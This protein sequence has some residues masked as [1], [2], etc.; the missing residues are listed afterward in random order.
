LTGV[1]AA[2][3]VTVMLLFL[4]GLVQHMP[5][6]VLAAVV[7]A[8]SISLFE[9]SALRHLWRMRK[10]EL[11]LAVVS[12]LGVALVGV[13]EGIVIAVILSILQFFERA[14]RPYSAVLGKMDE[15]PGHHDIQRHPEARQIP[16]LIILRWDAPLFFANAQYLPRFNPQF[17]RS[18]RSQTILG[19]GHS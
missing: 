17:D 6:P 3:L 13:L 18:G 11:A 1:F 4:P 8:A 2:I 7:I 15:I 16:G 10:S 19:I 12:I 5:Q 9:L 14:W